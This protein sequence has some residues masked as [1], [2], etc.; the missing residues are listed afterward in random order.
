MKLG[1]RSTQF[2]T[3]RPSAKMGVVCLGFTLIELL[4]VISIIALMISILLPV[5]SAAKESAAVTQCLADLGEIMKAAQAYATDNDPTGYGSYPTQPWHLGNDYGGFAATLVSEWVYGGFQTSIPHPDY[6]PGGDW[7]VF[8]TEVRPFTKYVSPG[9]AGKSIVKN[10]I[11]PSDKSHISSY[12]DDYGVIPTVDDRYG[13]WEINGNSY[14]I[15]WYW[16]DDPVF[17][18]TDPDEPGNPPKR[19]Y[20]SIKQMSKWG[21]MMLAKKVGGAAAEFPLFW[22]DTMD[23]YMHD[24]KPPDGSEGESQLQMLGV[25]WHRKL[26]MYSAAFYDGHTEYRFFDT[27]FTRGPGYNI[28][29]GQ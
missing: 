19:D 10:F 17:D 7:S 5:L 18:G 25:G 11:C 4:V 13:A 21:S 12:Q 14:P 6:G 3:P 24:A 16:Y 28:R 20:L 22:E 26:S 29:P 15:V 23:A 8:P 27:R 9:S 1:S 2:G